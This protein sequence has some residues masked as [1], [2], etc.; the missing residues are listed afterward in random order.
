[1]FKIFLSPRHTSVCYF[2]KMMTGVAYFVMENGK[3][4]KYGEENIDTSV[5]RVKSSH[6][7]VTY[8]LNPGTGTFDYSKTYSIYLAEPLAMADTQKLEKLLLNVWQAEQS[9]CK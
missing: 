7:G 2:R 3:P 6:T 5:I 9:L 1:M 4:I 8:K